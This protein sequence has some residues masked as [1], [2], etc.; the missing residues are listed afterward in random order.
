MGV[1]LRRKEG[2]VGFMEKVCEAKEI[3][4]LGMLEL[5]KFNVA[6]LGKWIWRLDS[7]ER[8]LWKE[9][10]ESKY[11]GWRSLRNQR[12]GRPEPL[13][14]KDLEEI[15]RSE[16]WKGSFEDNCIWEVRNGR[17][18]ML[19]K[20][21][22]LG[23]EAL[24]DKFPRLFSICSGKGDKLWQG[25]EWN[26]NL[27]WVWKIGWRRSLFE[28]EKHQELEMGRLM[29][30]KCIN[31]EKDDRWVWKENETAKYTVKSAYR[32]LK[33]EEQGEGGP[34]YEEVLAD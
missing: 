4:G 7:E 30:S 31:M 14:W 26:S 24:K 33:D 29:G 16:G 11:G 8:G 34:M 28:W 13:C 21:K 20:D 2:S 12:I 22:W 3:G 32:I 5:R 15:W 9:V 1:G 27:Q 6:L 23:D 17:E 10:V 18:I 25:G 19:W